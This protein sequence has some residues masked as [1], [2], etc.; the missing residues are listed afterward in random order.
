MK[1][2]KTVKYSYYLT[3]KTLEEDIDR[4]IEKAKKRDYQMDR[5]YNGGGL[6][7]IKQYFKILDEK[8]ENNEFEECKK[9]Y[10][11]LIPFLFYASGGQ[12]EN[13]FDYEDL[14]AKITTQFDNF[15]KNYFICLIK[16]CNIEDLAEAVSEYAMVLDIYGF[17]SDKKILL[18]YLDNEKLE[19][20]EHLILK[21]TEGVTKKD[22]AKKDIIYFILSLV[23][24]RKDKE[25]YILLCN[26][27]KDFFDDKELND[28][29]EEYEEND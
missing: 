8:F 18:K 3:E 25:R 15:V 20:L 29:I 23:R 11:K 27:F 22:Q 17:D 7:I 26:K 14:L 28:F 24:E 21:K 5:H 13:L 10:R 4:F 12:G 9:C 19:M 2:T 6:K 16:T 1:I